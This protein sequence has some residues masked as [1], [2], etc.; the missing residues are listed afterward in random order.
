MCGRFSLTTPAE[1]LAEAFGLDDVP[2]LSA[3]YNIAPSQPVAVVRRREGEPRRRLELVRWGLVPAWAKQPRRRG[4]L[5][6]ARSETAAG[7]PAFR[8]A[9]E[10]RRCL[11]P[12]DA[13][14]EWQAVPGS[15]AKQPYLIR[16]ADERPFALAGIWEPE[17]WGSGEGETCAIL[18]T[19][20]NE[21]L[22][23]LHNRMPVIVAAD[24]YAQW[25]D[26]GL[27]GSSLLGRVSR[28]FPAAAMVA[29]P[30]S[31]RVNDPGHDDPECA[32]PLDQV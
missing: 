6:N 8:D 24:D 27:R 25:L 26:L 23:P 2:D 9:L 31:R 28:P 13:F 32:Q 1:V 20:P 16:M 11:V 29:L 3:R 12:A 14:Y 18:T 19:A 4:P 5:I 30:V 17:P 10:K 22:E 21:L 7:S 15:K